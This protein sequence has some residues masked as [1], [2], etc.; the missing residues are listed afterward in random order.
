VREVLMQHNTAIVEQIEAEPGSLV[1]F[2]GCHAL[3][4][5]APVC[6]DTSRIALVFTFGEDAS[7]ANS[8]ETKSN[9]EWS[10]PQSASQRSRL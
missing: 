3:H 10:R 9:N 7:F 2:A 8:E 5:A 4:R 1:F 6:G